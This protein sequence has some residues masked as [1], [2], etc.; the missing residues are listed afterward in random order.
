MQVPNIIIIGT[1]R[2][3][4]HLLDALANKPDCSISIIGRD[5]KQ[6]K[7]LTSLHLG[8]EVIS[9][10]EILPGS[11]CLLCVNDSSIAQVASNISQKDCTLIH[12]SGVESL[13]SL[14]FSHEHSAVFWPIKSFGKDNAVNWGDIPVIAEVSSEQSKAAIKTIQNLL[15]CNVYY[16][17][18]EQRM[19]L[20]LAAVMVNNFSNFLFHQAFLWCKKNELPFESLIP[21][22]RQT[23]LNISNED[24]VKFQ[25]GPAARGDEET[26]AKHL[27]LLHNHESLLKLYSA[28]SSAIQN[29]ESAVI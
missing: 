9:Y 18:A 16:L 5:S 3:A 1:G 15:T 24:P 7:T 27:K 25:T 4:R 26:I 8:I 23:A 13:D 29:D 12:F 10:S 2:L 20:H 17:L 11:I 19:Q 6:L 28:I 21:I 22:I 14:K